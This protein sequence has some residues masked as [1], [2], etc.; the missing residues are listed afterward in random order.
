M[1]IYSTP[2][3]KSVKDE[4]K[5]IK[6]DVQ[7]ANDEEG[8]LALLSEHKLVQVALLDHLFISVPHERGF[9]RRFH[10]GLELDQCSSLFGHNTWF[11]HESR[12]G[13][14]LLLLTP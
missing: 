13:A 8:V 12:L 4:T 14:S 1:I 10:A 2:S 9:G 6:T 5:H 7:F 3:R 11:A